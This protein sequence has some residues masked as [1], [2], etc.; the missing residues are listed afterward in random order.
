MGKEVTLQSRHVR[1]SRQSV[2][3]SPPIVSKHAH[4]LPR[5]WL[6]TRS[7]ITCNI[8]PRLNTTVGKIKL[9]NTFFSLIFLSA[10]CE[11]LEGKFRRYCGVA[12]N[13]G[14]NEKKIMTRFI[15]RSDLTRAKQ[16]VSL[17]L[18]KIINTKVAFKLPK[19]NE[20]D[21]I[22]KPFQ[23]HKAFDA[24]VKYLL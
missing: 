10:Y 23:W 24:G 8:C 1:H 19:S 16:R 21:S 18:S 5:L 12:N 17:S 4:H 9:Y 22:L 2:S 7:S 6:C 15:F 11:V 3:K 13:Q 20:Y 14:M